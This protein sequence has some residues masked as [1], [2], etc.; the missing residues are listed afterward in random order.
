MA[1][2]AHA[3][4]SSLNLRKFDKFDKEGISENRIGQF[5]VLRTKA[6]ANTWNNFSYSG[7]GLDDGL[8]RVGQL[9]HAEVA[10]AVDDALDTLS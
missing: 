4:H 10:V 2:P 5:T 3:E 8:G 1:E 7:A 9:S 6:G